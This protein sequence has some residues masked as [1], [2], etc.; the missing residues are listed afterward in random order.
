MWVLVVAVGV[1]RVAAYDTTPGA[2]QPSPPHWPASS[3]L[4][5]V[6]GRSTLLMFVHPKCPCSRASLSEL[7]AIMNGD[8]DHASAI[9]VFLRPPGA[10]ADWEQVDT[11]TAAGH[12]PNATRFVDL[13]GAEADRFSARTSGQV[14]LYDA[15]GR[16][17]FA[18]G[19]TGSRGHAGENVG[20]QTVLR[21]LAGASADRA[22]HAVFGCA[23]WDPKPVDGSP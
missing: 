23:L 17:V 7:N 14:V 22:G 16:L 2:Q 1:K 4:T 11:W 6:A 19:I 10:P 20:R 13:D 9:V 18:G 3:R 8:R 12:V 5:P 15:D 21:L